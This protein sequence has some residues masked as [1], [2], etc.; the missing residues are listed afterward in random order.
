[1]ASDKNQALTV[2]QVTDS[3]LRREPDGTLL[4]MNTRR[5][6]DAVLSLVRANHENPDFVLATGDIAQ[7]GSTEAYECFHEKMQPFQCPVYWFSGNHDDPGVMAKAVR[8]PE[9]LAKVK[10][11]GPWKLI[12]LD[13][14]VRRKVYGKLAKKELQ[15]LKA[16][17]EKD[18]DKHV[19][20]CF[21]HHP[22]DVD[23]AWLDTIGLHNRDDFFAVIDGYEHVR[24][25]LWGHIHQEYDQMRNGVRLLAT[26]STCVQFKPYSEDFAVD[27]LAPGYRWLKLYPD[28]R[29]ETSVVRASHIEFEVDLSSKGY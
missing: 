6:L 20:I 22:V 7:D 10:I 4:G 18:Q 24:L 26:P 17:L 29:V 19:I 3:H 12:F 13:S 8:N 23:C 5:S 11:F 28:G 1:M 25:I 21:H 14:S 15:L 9:C 16:E 2:I 27:T